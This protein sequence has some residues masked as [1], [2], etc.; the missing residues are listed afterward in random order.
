MKRF[1]SQGC[2]Y[3]PLCVC[4]A[5]LYSL[6]KKNG[7]AFPVKENQF[8]KFSRKKTTLFIPIMTELSS[9]FLFQ[10]IYLL[11]EPGHIENREDFFIL[12]LDNSNSKLFPAVCVCVCSTYSRQ[13]KSSVVSYKFVWAIIS[14]YGR[15]R[16]DDDR[17]YH[18]HHHHHRCLVYKLQCETK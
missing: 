9:R 15:H 11:V 1:L 16:Q 7:L 8:Y 6:L 10:Y 13:P 3:N 5:L 12:F 14:I 18:H 2:G 4:V 17:R